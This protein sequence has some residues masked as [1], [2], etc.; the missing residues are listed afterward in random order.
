MGLESSMAESVTRQDT[1]HS[2]N[3]DGDVVGM[4]DTEQQSA[5]NGQEPVNAEAHS[6]TNSP[7]TKIIWTPKFLVV[8]A[9]VL[10]LGLSTESV[11]TEVSD[12]GYLPG[13][14]LLAGHTAILLG[15]WISAVVVVCSSSWI[16]IGTIFGLAWTIFSVI[17]FA[18]A[19]FQF[20]L[21]TAM[22]VYLQVMYS[23]SLLGAYI[24]LSI[25]RTELRTWDIWFYRVSIIGGL[26]FVLIGIFISPLPYGLPA[27]IAN[28]VGPYFVILSTL[29]WWGRPSCWRT[30]PGLT[31]LLGASTALTFLL[32]LPN[33]ASGAVHL[34]LLQ[35]SYLC[36]ILGLIRLIQSEKIE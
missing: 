11:L 23:G 12:T 30:Y 15:L 13:I 8:F 27:T 22:P 28:S 16:R 9:L 26:V 36:M 32:S 20:G 6:N 19:F 25:A 1:H 10:V 21:D 14:W 5:T 35:V 3:D 33:V 29:I 4:Q 18:L 7:Q 24:C 17:N 34:F 31:F 2:R